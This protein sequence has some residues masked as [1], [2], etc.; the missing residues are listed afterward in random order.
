MVRGDIVS[1]YPNTIKYLI[2]K[3]GIPVTLLAEELILDP[4]TLNKCIRG[5]QVS[6]TIIRKLSKYFNVPNSFLSKSLSDSTVLCEPVI[7]DNIDQYTHDS[8]YD[9]DFDYQINTSF[10]NQSNIIDDIEVFI[11]R[12]TIFINQSKR[13]RK[14]ETKDPLILENKLQAIKT[15][16]E[17]KII[18]DLLADLTDAIN[19]LVGRYLY[20]EQQEYT[21][22]N[23]FMGYRK[24]FLIFVPKHNISKITYCDNGDSPPSPELYITNELYNNFNLEYWDARIETKNFNKKEFLYFINQPNEPL[25]RWNRN[26][27]EQNDKDPEE[28]F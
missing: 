14:K 15:V 9:V 21:Q 11:K 19:V 8:Q 22:F 3:A 5:E 13:S 6:A 20:W 17:V 26:F 4:K 2:D 7:K 12:L 23:S 18:L 25:E 10:V 24:Q 27:E 1:V 16:R 28:I